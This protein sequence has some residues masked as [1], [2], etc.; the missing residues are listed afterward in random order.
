MGGRKLQRMVLGVDPSMHATGWALALPNGTIIEFGHLKNPTELEV[1]DVIRDCEK[2]AKGMYGCKLKLS[3]EDQFL[4]KNPHVFKKLV[5]ARQVWCVIA[6][7]KRLEVEI[8]SA[9]K[10]RGLAF[11]SVGRKSSKQWKK[12]AVSKM[13][14][15]L[16][17]QRN[18][19]EEDIDALTED[20]A[21]ACWI[22]IAGGRDSQ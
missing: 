15:Y 8:Y 4:G 6:G 17:I 3:I 1:R 16:T 7:L 2:I 10:W 19:E 11:G 22:A 12:F 14:D 21:E 13:T 9:Q 18:F 5:E 20:E